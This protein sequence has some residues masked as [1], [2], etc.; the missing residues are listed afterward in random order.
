MILYSKDTLW[1]DD[2]TE[3]LHKLKQSW[4][5][6]DKE[7]LI[8]I[9]KLK[10]WKKNERGS[11]YKLVNIKKN[12]DI[13]SLSYPILNMNVTHDVE[14][15]IG[16][17]KRFKKPLQDGDWVK[18]VITLSEKSEREKFDNPLL[19]TVI[20]LEVLTKIPF[21][22]L[23]LSKL[24]YELI[25]IDDSKFL[26]SALLNYHIQNIQKDIDKEKNKA[27]LEIAQ[28]IKTL[29][30]S[31][32][33]AKEENDK[34]I[35]SLN[36]EINLRQQDYNSILDNIAKI[37]E[38]RNRNNAKLA[39]IT[40]K[41]LEYQDVKKNLENNMAN[42]N[43][44]IQSKS[45]ILE[46]LDLLDNKDLDKLLLKFDSVDNREGHEFSRVFDSDY[47]QSVA[48]I[49]AYLWQQN[50]FYKRSVLEDFFA[51]IRT[52]DLIVL[53]GDSG[54][55]KTNLVKSFAKA[56]GG[57]AIIIPVK[58]NWTS[59]EDLLGYYNP[60]ENKYLSTRFLDALVEAQENPNTP[61]FI[62][63]DE[64]NLARVE[65]YF[66]DFLSLLEERDEQPEIQLFSSS[67]GD[68]LAN[69]L[70]N[71]ISLVNE[72]S[73]KVGNTEFEGFI[74]ILKDEEFNAKL[75]EL[76]GF[77]DGDSILKYHSYLKKMLHSFIN[78]RASIKLPKN[79]RIIGAINVDE[80]THY[81]SPKILDRVHVVK[82]SSPLLSDWL[83]NEITS[84]NLDMKLPIK[85]SLSDLGERT[86]YPDFDRENE[87][88]RQ[89]VLLVRNYLDVLG[90]E[91]GLRTIRQALGYAQ[92]IAPFDYNNGV[93][94]NNIILHKILPK[95]LFDGNKKI[96]EN[97]DK[98][99]VLISMINYL[100][101][102]LNGIELDEGSNC[103]I[104]L[105]KLIRN[106]N[107]N[108]WIVNYWTK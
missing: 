86:P 100:K 81:L 107:S 21:G 102:L 33:K 52:N 67:E 90:I 9:G 62:C 10:E 37:D 99:D 69:E 47:R 106:A 23:E 4:G 98:K 28:K 91:F 55:G 84:F 11:L 36:E 26:E 46:R 93:I 24:N 60:L 50:I 30:E 95:L 103:L 54:S 87:L 56:V 75:H 83:E 40:A 97:A 88:V 3:L 65:Y 63:L 73:A 78:N 89:L 79:V 27:S 61:Y 34:A 6:S 29:K 43:E 53:A 94:L 70:K 76:C 74:D 22:D 20:S 8:V 18:A 64:M 66:A 72:T 105:D 7:S 49:Q 38:E 80:T 108:G 42:L 77:K 85:F 57:K 68:I 13:S 71:F 2:D 101:E 15:Y 32:D 58:P 31:F 19:L 16:S 5:Y 45:T 1:Q 59:A 104:E 82:F 25:T 41:I 92:A 48:Y 12:D 17:L 44:I 51:L 14:A 96:S 35:T 39:K